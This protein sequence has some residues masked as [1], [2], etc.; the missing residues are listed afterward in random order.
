MNIA[1]LQYITQHHPQFTHAQLAEEACAAG[2]NWVQ[3]RSKG[4]DSSLILKEATAI[5][6]TCKKHQ[7]TFIV[8]D[9]VQVAIQVK[10]D[11]VHL[12]K[13]DMNI[14]SARALL[15][16]EFII[17]ATANTFNDV[18][19][20]VED[21]ADYIGLGPFRFTSTKE[22]LSPV[23]GLEGYIQIMEQCR[24]H[25]LNI[26]IIAIGGILPEDLPA[27]MKAGIFGVAVASA[28]TNSSTKE[29]TVTAFKQYLRL[30]KEISL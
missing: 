27:L 4:S 17:G 26:P 30:K 18:L 5:S 10:A 21:G 23:L 7:A 25:Q 15:G 6:N 9:H 22:K 28:I 29:N 1:D 20:H 8:N 24:L 14:K 13:Q 19:R 12:G 11:G 16:K 3:Y 2:V